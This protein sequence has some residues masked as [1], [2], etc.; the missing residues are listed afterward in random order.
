M[1]KTGWL[2]I[3]TLIVF[4]GCYTMMKHPMVV[5]EAYPDM[6]YS[7][8]FSENCS[9]CH[10]TG[11]DFKVVQE[12]VQTNPGYIYQSPRWHTFYT[13]PWWN[14]AMF[15]GSGSASDPSTAGGLLPTTSSRSRF[16]G[17]SGNS[18]YIPPASGTITGGG[19]STSTS[20]TTGSSGNSNSSGS[21]SSSTIR[22]GTTSPS[23]RNAI[24]GS[25][26][27]GNSGSRK[28]T[29]RKRK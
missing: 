10:Q 24:R 22:N 5:D 27:S 13:A 25:G 7:V 14:R 3:L 12:S 17:G 28:V 26:G 2:V 6:P 9:D 16:P 4:S 21:N 29:K 1:R 19:S 20:I 15:Y 23:S 18:G 11:S 8:D